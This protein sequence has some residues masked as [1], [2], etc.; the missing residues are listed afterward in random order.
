MRLLFGS[1]LAVAT[2]P[3]LL[4]GCVVDGLVRNECRNIFDHGV[5][6]RI[7]AVVVDQNLFGTAGTSL[8]D[9]LQGTSHGAKV[10][11][12]AGSSQVTPSTTIEGVEFT[13]DLDSGV[14]VVV[15]HP[16][17]EKNGMYRVGDRVRFM[18]D[19]QGTMWVWP[20]AGA[21]TGIGGK[22]SAGDSVPL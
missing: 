14:E 5:I 17:N 6:T 4:A 13:V 1:M 19:C 8:G 21:I 3:L 16:R 12:I 2:L 20:A 11:N 9:R 22:S 7:E 18:I 15:A 10:G